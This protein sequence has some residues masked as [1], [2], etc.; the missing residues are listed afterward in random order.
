[1]TGVQ[2]CALPILH[3]SWSVG[4]VAISLVY[5]LLKLLVLAGAIVLVETTNAKMRFFRVPDLL[6]MAFTLAALGLVSTF[7]F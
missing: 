6:A 2:T 1:M 3:A 7:L 5:L 4:G